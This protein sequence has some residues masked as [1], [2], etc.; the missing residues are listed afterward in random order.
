MKGSTFWN[1]TCCGTVKVRHVSEENSAPCSGSKN[2]LSKQLHTVLYQ[3]IVNFYQPL[4]CLPFYILGGRSLHLNL[5][6]C[7]VRNAPLKYWSVQA[8]SI[9]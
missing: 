3:K 2:Q 4:P 5:V 1:M 6:L 7:C 8:L 9:I